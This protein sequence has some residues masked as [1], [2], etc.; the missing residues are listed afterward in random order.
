MRVCPGCG[1][2]KGDEDFSRSSRN[3]SGL[4][5]RCKECSAASSRAYYEQRVAAGVRPSTAHKYCPRCRE[6]KVFSLNKGAKD[7]LQ[8]WC[9]DCLVEK[10][11]CYNLRVLCERFGQP[12]EVIAMLQQGPCDICG[13]TV[14][15]GGGSFHVD[16]DHTT[17]AI[18]GSL[19]HSCN[20]A[21]GQF[22]D[23]PDRL[24]QAAAYLERH[25]LLMEM[26]RESLASTPPKE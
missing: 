15:R 6:I 25:T 5:S 10:A 22:N 24:R 23:D 21:L 26:R 18:R 7:G 11:R 1:T 14:A 12:P 17:G 3:S 4:Q 19:C 2:E 13:A 9:K 16:H 8:G 20:V